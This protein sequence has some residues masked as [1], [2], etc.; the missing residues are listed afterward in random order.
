MV[1]ND[2]ELIEKVSRIMLEHVEIAN[3]FP[4]KHMVIGDVDVCTIQYGKGGELLH[5][6]YHCPSPIRDLIISNINRGK[7]IRNTSEMFGKN[8]VNYVYRLNNNGKL[9]SVEVI[10]DFPCIE[11]I[12]YDEICQYGL[13]C[14][15]SELENLK[16]GVDSVRYE[17]ISKCLYDDSGK[18][19]TYELSVPVPNINSSLEIAR[20][21]V[22][23][24]FY[25]DELL[26]KILVYEYF[27]AQKVLS[28]KQN[29]KSKIEDSLNSRDQYNFIA[30][31]KEY[32]LQR[33][34]DGVA[35]EYNVIDIVDGKKQ[36][37]KAVSLPKSKQRKV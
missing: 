13:A 27:N 31:H 23:E 21:Y 4:K 35:I 16:K 22:E 36:N 8:N 14:A 7:L 32:Y 2:G 26:S 33:N 5:R 24:Y 25:E 1:L 28:S 10:D 19:I 18:I 17:T 3:H 15:V 9:I 12:W 29:L 6:G 30:C 37:E 34:Q 11:Y 20:L